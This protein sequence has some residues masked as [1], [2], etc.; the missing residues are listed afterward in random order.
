MTTGCRLG[1]ILGLRWEA[2]DLDRG[3]MQ[4]VTVA[5]EVPR[6]VWGLGEPKTDQSR[7]TV[8]LTSQAVD[9]LHNHHAKQIEERFK[10]QVGWNPIGLVFCSRAGTL[11][12]PNNFRNRDFTDILNKAGSKYL[13]PHPAGR[14]SGATQAIDAGAQLY[15]V[16]QWLGHASISTTADIYAHAQEGASRSVRDMMERLHGTNPEKLA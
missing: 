16:Q 4:I 8:F 5:K 6:H 3:T 12:N 14:H 7:R 10:H 15:D 9:A 2:V 1:E 13:S 11:I